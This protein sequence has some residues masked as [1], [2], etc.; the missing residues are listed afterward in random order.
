MRDLRRLLILGTG[1]LAL[2][3]SGGSSSP[4]EPSSSVPV[5]AGSWTGDWTVAGIV[6][7]PTLQLTQNGG[8]LAGTFSVLASTFNV[9]GTVNTSLVMN[10][11]VVNGGCGTLT[12]DGLANGLLPSQITGSINLDTTGCTN[13]GRFQGPVVWKKAIAV[14]GRQAPRTGSLEELR[15]M[16]P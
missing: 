6:L 3:C 5:V 16:L 9:T 15:R 2:A 7:H 11:A 12:G 10:W 4:T 8:A 13:P 14:A 1:L